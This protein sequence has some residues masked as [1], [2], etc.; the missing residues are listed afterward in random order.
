[1]IPCIYKHA[2]M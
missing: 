1:M 2:F